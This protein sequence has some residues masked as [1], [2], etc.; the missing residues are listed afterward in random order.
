MGPRRTV[1]ISEILATGISGHATIAETFEIGMTTPEG[2]PVVGFV[3]D[4]T[5][6]DGRPPY[7]VRLGH[8]VP[9]RAMPCARAGNKVA[10]RVDRENPQRVA[11][12]WNMPL[13]S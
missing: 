13:M 2:E 1:S 11:I 4:V 5:A 10:V 8:R 12:D 7:Q 3:L 6:S 9:H